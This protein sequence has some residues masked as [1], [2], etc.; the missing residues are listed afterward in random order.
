MAEKSGYKVITLGVAYENDVPVFHNTLIEI[1][2]TVTKDKSSKMPIQ[3]ELRWKC[4]LDGVKVEEAMAGFS[5]SMQIKLA[6]IREQ[7]NFV[8]L[9]AALAEGEVEYK[10]I[11]TWT[12]TGK[13]GRISELGRFLVKVGYSKEEAKEIIAD[14]T[15]KARAQEAYDLAMA[16]IEK[17]I[18]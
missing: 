3:K 16:K 8:E 15:R 18:I 9:V 2:G 17:P 7:D 10:D 5:S 13:G 11:E 14:P 6:T 1:W 4:R 12:D